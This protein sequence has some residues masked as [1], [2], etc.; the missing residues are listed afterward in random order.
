MAMAVDVKPSDQQLLGLVK[1]L[2]LDALDSLFLERRRARTDRRR[3]RGG[4]EESRLLHLRG[5]WSRVGRMRDGVERLGI[6]CRRCT[7][8]GG[9]GVERRR[10][11]H[12]AGGAGVAAPR[13]SKRCIQVRAGW[14]THTHMRP[15]TATSMGDRP[16]NGEAAVIA[17][18]LP[19]AIAASGSAASATCCPQ[20]DGTTAKHQ[21]HTKTDT[22]AAAKPFHEQCPSTRTRQKRPKRLPRR[23]PPSRRTQRDSRDR[24]SSSCVPTLREMMDAEMVPAWQAFMEASE[25]GRP[26]ARTRP[27]ADRAGAQGGASGRVA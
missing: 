12:C 13:A 2:L 4:R 26:S 3:R 25:V 23:R 20:A 7:C 17:S 21:Q 16:R 8:A 18:I 22:A 15:T 5:R 27:C 1:L 9:G 6:V 14:T 11:L 10:L 24:A 19:V